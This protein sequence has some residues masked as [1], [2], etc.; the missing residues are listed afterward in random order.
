MDALIPTIIRW[1]T[2]HITVRKDGW[3][4]AGGGHGRWL[5]NGMVVGN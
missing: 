2:T 4:I 5:V 1:L 3:L